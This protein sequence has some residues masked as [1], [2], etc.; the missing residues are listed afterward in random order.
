[1]RRKPSLGKF[2]LDTLS[3]GMYNNP[4]MVLREYIQNSVDAIDELASK[5][6]LNQEDAMIDISINGRDK[7]LMIRDNGA[8][9]LAEDAWSTLHNIG[10]SFKRADLNR[11]FRGIGRLGGL[12]YCDLLRFATKAAKE[13]VYSTSIWD[14]KKLRQLIGDDNRAIDLTQIISEVTTFTQSKYKNDLSDH[15]FIVEMVGIK[16]SRDI[17]LNVPLIKS[18]I[19]EVAP[20][21]FNE[22]IFRYAK[23]VDQNLRAKVMNY[24]TY[25]IIVNGDQIYKPYSDI[26]PIGQENKDTIKGIDFID[27]G[28]DDEPL[29]NGWL[30]ELTLK[31]CISPSS[32]MDGVRIRQG[33]ILVGDKNLLSSFYREP[34]FNM[35]LVGELHIQNHNLVLNARRDD[36]EDN[37]CKDEFYNSFIKLIGLPYSKRIRGESMTEA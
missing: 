12:G 4:L 1:M 17:L 21:P 14:C 13:S 36:F 25:R 2:T 7:S 26:I 15:F 28:N 3:I 27:L 8:G 16:S 22:R 9:V 30:A 34:R 23:T 37:S 20:V 32:R 35:Y 18:Y 6:Q 10:K 33:N 11:G 31:G 24:Q 29:A 5:E 19:S